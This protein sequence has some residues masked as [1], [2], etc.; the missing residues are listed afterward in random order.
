[1]SET[2]SFVGD[3]PPGFEAAFRRFQDELQAVCESAPPWPER[4]VACTGAALNFAA[5]NPTVAHVLTNETLAGGREGYE[6]FERLVDYAAAP[7]AAGRE[8][9]PETKQ[10]PPI[11]ER[12]LVSGIALIVGEHVRQNRSSDLPQMT[13][14]VARFV[15]TPYL[16]ERE[17]DRVAAAAR[18]DARSSHPADDG[19]L[20]EKSA[21]SRRELRNR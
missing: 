11:T 6:R 2:E 1:M 13:A 5:I 12:V 9:V 7:L 19:E 15:L 16:G 3:S 4:I 8:R 21:S 14:D 18:A 10:P 17:A 20:P